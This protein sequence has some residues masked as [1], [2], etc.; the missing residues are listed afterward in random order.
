MRNTPCHIRQAAPGARRHR[1]FTLIELMI[2][3]SIGLG[4]LLA[5]A[6]VF[7][8][9]SIMQAELTR[10]SQ[11]IENG[12]FATQLLQEDLRHAG[13]YGRYVA[14]ATKATVDAMTGLPDPCSTNIDTAVA[15]PTPLQ[16]SLI[17][18]VSGYDA[19]TA[20][21]AATA[22]TTCSFAADNFK[23]GTDILVVRRA[24]SKP[25]ALASLV[26]ATNYLQ[27]V[28]ETM[29]LISLQAIA[30]VIAK[31]STPA[32]F[33]LTGGPANEAG[34]IRRFRVHIY[35]VSPCSVPASGTTCSS[36]AD[37]GTPIPTLKRLE[38]AA[39]GSF[40]I[41]PLVEGIEDLQIDY[42]VDTVPGTVGAADP[43]TGDGMPDTY[44]KNPTVAEFTQVTS[45]RIYVLARSTEKS[46]DYTDTKT[47]D[48]GLHGTYTP[49]ATGD[50]NK[51]K[52]H[53]FATTV[54]L[55]NVVG[56]R[57]K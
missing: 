26:G 10:T 42:G 45:A 22:L 19:P 25:T 44:T 41:V 12:R 36:A 29:N 32:A 34:E 3:I 40:T 2:S 17:F 20:A 52:R 11:Q 28:A 46:R 56:W 43:Y 51:Y 24:D 49:T 53:L 57:E 54:R 38:L 9:S 18:A 5:L 23:A 14:W 27:S 33:N 6:T 16:S 8:N 37:G 1:G 55:Q 15:S 30:P 13:F 31:G 50:A 47:Y 39:N 35:F 4:L 7:S 48:L 21:A